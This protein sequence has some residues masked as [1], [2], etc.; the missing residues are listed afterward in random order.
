[1]E[2]KLL[3]LSISVINEASGH[4]LVCATL[5]AKYINNLQK[6]EKKLG[7]L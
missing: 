6:L 2:V 7:T 3:A 5:S 4:P 1:M